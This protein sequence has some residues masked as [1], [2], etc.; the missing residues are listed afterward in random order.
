[1]GDLWIWETTDVGD[2]LGGLLM[3][4]TAE[5]GLLRW[6]LLMWGTYWEGTVDVGTAGVGVTAEQRGVLLM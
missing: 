5:R 1:M 2:L 6:E 4:A 3:W